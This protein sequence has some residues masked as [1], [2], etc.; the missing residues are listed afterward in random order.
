MK[1]SFLGSRGIPARYSGFERFVQEVSVRLAQRG[2]EVTVYNRAPFNPCREKNFEGVRLVRLPTLPTKATDT[3]VHGGICT[4]HALA[5]ADGAVLYYCG[6]GNACWMRLARLWG[7]VALLNVDGADFARAKW[8]GFGRWWLRQSERWAGGASRVIA[9]NRE[10]QKRYLR[11]HGIDAEFIPYGTR[12]LEADPGRGELER[13]GLK[14]KEFFLY[15]SRLTPENGALEVIRGYRQSGSTLPLVVVGDEPY[16]KGYLARLR[17]EAEGCPQILFT[18][19]L[20]GEG[21][22]QLSWHARAFFLGSAFDATRPVL[23]EQMG[24]GGCVVLQEVPGN[25]EI[26]GEAAWWVD[27]DDPVRGFAEAFR[28]LTGDAARA[29]AL[30]LAARERVRTRYDWERVTSQYEE[31]FQKLLAPSSGDFP[32][33][34]RGDFT[35]NPH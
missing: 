30:G 34:P 24:A 17:A 33:R 13:L 3:L 25:R 31:L 22:R 28:A 32:A 23:L 15:V 1:V 8:S 2:H 35:E 27:P 26:A 16:E 20:F 29:A 6:V 7:R 19:Y 10:I 18:G 12:L 5:R 21:Y 14:T 11:E 4:L 9:D